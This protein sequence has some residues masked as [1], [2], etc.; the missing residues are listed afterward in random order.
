MRV[1]PGLLREKAMQRDSVWMDP[2]TFAR[3]LKVV[4]AKAAARPLPPPVL[5]EDQWGAADGL[6]LRVYGV[7][8]WIHKPLVFVPAWKDS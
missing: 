3:T 6:S 2:A 7:A 5:A 1:R 8:P 4:K